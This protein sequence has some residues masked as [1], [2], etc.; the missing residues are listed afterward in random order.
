MNFNGR[1]E[2]AY[3]RT[4]MIAGTALLCGSKG[5]LLGLWPAATWVIPG[6]RLDMS[7]ACAWG[8]DC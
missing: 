4:Q 1:C 8:Q 2:G 7:P 3:R 6:K 5:V